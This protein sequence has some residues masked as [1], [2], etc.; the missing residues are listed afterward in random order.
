MEW[1][2][3]KPAAFVVLGFAAQRITQ[4]V[5]DGFYA[6]SGYPVP[7]YEGQLS[8]SAD[9]LTGWYSTMQANG[10]LGIYWQTQFVDFA[11][12]AATLL[13]FIALLSAVAQAFPAGTRGRRLARRMIWLGAAAPVFDV[14]ENLL[15]FLML[16]DPTTISP[17]IALLYSTAAAL[18]FTCFIAVYLWAIIALP[19]AATLRRRA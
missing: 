15:S 9:K 12:I 13:F 11:F 6:R 4:T 3:V 19:T 17:T 2:W 10:T 8:F 5:L 14:L 16:P 7:Y 18:K 1:K